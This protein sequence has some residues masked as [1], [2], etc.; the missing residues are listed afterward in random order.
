[1]KKLKIY[2]ELI[3]IKAKLASIVPFLLGLLYFRFNIGNINIKL[4]FILLIAIFLFNVSVD[5]LNNYCDYNNAIDIEKYKYKTNIIGRENLNK[6]KILISIIICILISMFLGIYL[7]ISKGIILLFLGIYCFL[8]GILYSYGPYPISN[9]PLGEFFSG[10]TMGTLIIYITILVNSQNINEINIINVVIFSIPTVLSISS[11]MLVNNLCDIEEDKKNGRK[12]LAIIIGRKKSIQLL[13][14]LYLIS[15]IS[16]IINVILKIVP[17]IY[18][19]VLTIYFKVLKNTKEIEKNPI[20][21]YA[22]KFGIKNFALILISQVL[23]YFLG[24]I[25]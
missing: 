7:V 22:F 10:T 25:M 18:L 14:I 4:T 2:L 16:V 6:N 20:K 23:L 19:L 12:T 3:E 11:L 1:M 9:Y 24:L 5:M 13:K 17:I 15:F 8:I 21:N